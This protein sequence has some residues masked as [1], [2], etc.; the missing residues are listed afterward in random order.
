MVQITL[1]YVLLLFF[2]VNF[3]YISTCYM[4]YVSRTRIVKILLVV[5][6]IYAL[7]IYIDHS[8]NTTCENT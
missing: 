4:S 7:L 3:F 6:H 8:E 5:D 1:F 2:R